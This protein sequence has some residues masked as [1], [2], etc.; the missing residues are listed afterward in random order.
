MSQ[1]DESQGTTRYPT[2]DELDYQRRKEAGFPGLGVP[3]NE[4]KGE[5]TA[6]QT[7]FAVEGND[8]SAYI[9][10]TSDR[11]T[12]ASET[13][14]PL[15]AQGSTDSDAE[16]AREDRVLSQ[17][18]LVAPSG[19]TPEGNQTGGGGSTQETLL[20]ATS[21]EALSSE[22]AKPPSTEK[23]PADEAAPGTPTDDSGQVEKGTFEGSTGET[24][25]ESEEDKTVVSASASPAP[26]GLS[27]EGEN[28][29]ATG[30]EKEPVRTPAPAK[31]ASSTKSNAS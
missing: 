3:A 8:T 5:V 7:Q 6:L 16:V 31:K 23:V 18:Y 1:T 11:M 27:G 12:Y 2:N 9:G 25:S 14:Q 20:T 19:P 21:G 13:E 29:E 4:S 15:L 26:S 28:T 24:V 10:V 30:S 22:I 17:E